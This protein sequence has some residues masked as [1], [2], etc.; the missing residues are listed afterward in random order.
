MIIHYVVF[1]GYMTLVL[2]WIQGQASNCPNLG[3]ST[4]AGGL[5]VCQNNCLNDPDC[6]LINFCPAGGDCTIKNRCCL[7]NCNNND[8]QLTNQWKGWDIYV[9]GTSCIVFKYIRHL[10]ITPIIN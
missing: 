10:K 4:V 9:K 3:C 1:Q 2:G 6:N 7:R 5:S 8:Y